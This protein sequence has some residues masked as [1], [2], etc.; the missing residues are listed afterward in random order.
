[1]YEMEHPQRADSLHGGADAR[2]A[3]LGAAQ[4]GAFSRAQA[5][6]AGATR[7]LIRHRISSNR[8]TQVD[9]FCFRITGAPRTWRQSLMEASLSW[10]DG[11]AISHRSGAALWR[12]PDFEATFVELTVPRD[13][14]RKAPGIVHRNA[15]DPVDVTTID[16]IPVT[17]PSRTLIDIA[18]VCARGMVEDAL[19]DALR[20]G[21]VSIPRLRWC[22]TRL[23]DR[24]GMGV[25]RALIAARAP[26]EAIS[27]SKLETMLLR[28]LRRAKLPKPIAQ[29]D[30]C[31]G[32][33]VVAR[34][35]FAYPDLRLAIEA[36]G[37]WFHSGRRRWQLDRERQ[38]RLTL[39]GWRVV[40]VTWEDLTTRP[41]AV[42][43]SVR[44]A[45]ALP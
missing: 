12:Y 10:G 40:H 45:L 8:W 18:S 30:I 36:D 23:G 43:D 29:Y 28:L 26:G 38:N 20:R 5:I 13:R 32:R 7:A 9:R 19:D 22:V 39:L 37:Y 33:H 2:I 42:V 34:A 1:M 14:Q 44:A 4:F 6:N 3:A 25:I 35:D 24:P 17:T 31:D 16:G 41:R 15:L 21:L 27:E 11:A